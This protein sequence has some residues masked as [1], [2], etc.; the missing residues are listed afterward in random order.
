MDVVTKIAADIG[1][2]RLRFADI[3]SDILIDEPA[4]AALDEEGRAVAVG[5]RAE[6]LLNDLPG[7]YIA[8]YPIKNGRIEDAELLE[9]CVEKIMKKLKKSY[10]RMLPPKVFLCVRSGMTDIQKNELRAVLGTSASRDVEFIPEAIAASYGAEE[11]A[12]GTETVLSVCLGAGSAEAV[13]VCMGSVAESTELSASGTYINDEIASRIRR[14][15]CIWAGKGSVEKLKK[16]IGAECHENEHTLICAKNIMTGLPVFANIDHSMIRDT[17]RECLTK[18][19][20]EIKRMLSSL[21]GELYSDVMKKEMLISGGGAEMP[22]VAEFFENALGMKVR[23]TDEPR[24][25][26]VKGIKSLI[27]E[28]YIKTGYFRAPANDI[29]VE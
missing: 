27:G 28:R 16:D 17:V 18:A 21:P 8:A 11:N 4:L 13:V 15:L 7:K 2:K 24:L 10:L 5:A 6:K 25:C 22:G 14:T 19:A 23:V 9:I 26:S 12:D 3:D 1:T 29:S 20:D